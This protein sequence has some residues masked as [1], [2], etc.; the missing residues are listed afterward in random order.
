MA[1]KFWEITLAKNEFKVRFGKIGSAGQTTLKSFPD[2]ATA[3]R[4]AEKLITEKLKKGYS[5]VSSQ[6]TA[7][8]SAKKG[9]KKAAPKV[10]T[11][12][13]IVSSWLSEFGI[14][15]GIDAEVPDHLDPV[16]I[17]WNL[18]HVW[19]WWDSYDEAGSYAIPG[20]Y[21]KHEV[22][23]DRFV[24]AWLLGTKSNPDPDALIV[25]V[26]RQTC[27][28]CETAGCDE[29]D[30]LGWV[31]TDHLADLGFILEWATPVN[32][33][34]SSPS[35]GKQ[36]KAPANQEASSTLNCVACAEVIKAN[37]KLC[38]HCGTMQDDP[39][40]ADNPDHINAEFEEED[41][42][43]GDYKLTE[44]D[45]LC[46]DAMVHLNQLVENKNLERVHFFDK[47]QSIILSASFE[48][49]VI[50]V[51]F[52]EKYGRKLKSF[53]PEDDEDYSRIKHVY[54]EPDDFFDF[55]QEDTGFALLEE[56]FKLAG[57]E[58]VED[59]RAENVLR[60]KR[61]SKPFYLIPQM[62]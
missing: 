35:G 27:E 32:S 52:P 58:S 11:Q 16:R 47:K 13:E 37:A 55:D 53:T 48:Y 42:I 46:T 8:P 7:Q 41:Q 15:A 45:N 17:G 2:A 54:L 33:P 36:T 57:C 9:S 26:D 49:G 29:C 21:E 44:M 14:Y 24:A 43:A 12:R 4:E 56:L 34:V 6:P 28:S 23:G 1:E 25:I 3:S 22:E 18:D 61:G 38:K 19:T 5:E 50:D 62:K 51:D 10:L 60:N 20:Y 30:D 39:R 31:E 59:V 40:F